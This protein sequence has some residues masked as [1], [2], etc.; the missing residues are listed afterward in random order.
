MPATGVDAGA[1]GDFGHLEAIAIL[2]QPLVWA[3]IGRRYPWA[4]VGLD[5]QAK[6]GWGILAVALLLFGS[7]IAHFLAATEQR[8]TTV[9]RS[10][11]ALLLVCPPLTAGFDVLS[12][13]HF[14][15]FGYASPGPL[16]ALEA[17]VFVALGLW[18]ASP[19]A[20]GRGVALAA[21][22]AAAHR[23]GAAAL[24]PLDERRSDMFAVIVRAAGVWSEGG[25]PY[26]E[27][28]PPGLKY[29]PGTWLAHSPSV[30]LG[31]DPRILGSVILLG[32][33]LALARALNRAE[34]GAPA[35]HASA[36]ELL[37]MLVLLNPY[38]AFRHDLYFD[39][40]LGLTVA[41]FYFG[42]LG[43]G[44]RRSLAVLVGLAAATRQWAWVY[45]PF[46]L[47]AAA[48]ATNRAGPAPSVTG[49]PTICRPWALL[50][51]FALAGAVCALS[52][53]IVVVPMIVQD[54]VAFRQGAFAFV[55]ASF[56]EACLG[57][58][59]LAAGLGLT[60]VLPAL[61]AAICLT[62]FG[63]SVAAALRGSANPRSVLATGWFVWA[64]V[65]LLNPFLENYFYLSLGFAAAGGAVGARAAR[66]SS[67]A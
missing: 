56:S 11:M 25:R 28:G 12:R 36:T 46:A 61:Q 31:I 37:T 67:G 30:L 18:L 8:R 54:P 17:I 16:L 66:L 23:L 59:A 6:I 26:V 3:G 10:A 60:E 4:L 27:V 35:G 1:A 53:A 22:A 32:I 64:G 50:G 48:V 62:G 29:L 55:G 13:R 7:P 2:A 42:A 19:G 52:A 33:G 57:V 9:R 21:V 34:R 63:K 47:L 65:V 58:A 41:V 44:R 51:R 45:G 24:F 39:A 15:A 49:A 40:F 5:E 20:A 14:V 38:H 43:R